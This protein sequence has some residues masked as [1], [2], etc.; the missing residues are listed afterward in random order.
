MRHCSARVV[1]GAGRNGAGVTETEYGSAEVVGDAVAV[2]SWAEVGKVWAE[3]AIEAAEG[4][5]GTAGAVVVDAALVVVDA[6][7]RAHR[8]TAGCAED[9]GRV[10]GGSLAGCD[11][12]DTADTRTL[13]HGKASRVPS[14]AQC[15]E[16]ELQPVP[17]AYAV[18]A[19]IPS[20]Q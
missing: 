4:G 14:R 8:D 11:G 3:D 6:V 7:V 1:C 12:A 5:T 19:R 9:A 17:K 20:L 18:A 2:V 15:G 13:R 16:A 10:A